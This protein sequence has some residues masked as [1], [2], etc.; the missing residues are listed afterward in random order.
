MI[1][2]ANCWFTRVYFPSIFLWFLSLIAFVTGK[3]KTGIPYFSIKYLVACFFL[4]NPID[5]FRLMDLL[6][7]AIFHGKLINYQNYQTVNPFEF[8]F[9]DG[10]IYMYIHIILWYIHEYPVIA[11]TKKMSKRWRPKGYFP[12]ISIGL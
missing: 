1:S 3:I 11:A 9:I 6:K 4:T 5:S 8:R 10:Y 7:I 2:I 12:M